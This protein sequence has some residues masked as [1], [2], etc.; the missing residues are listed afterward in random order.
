MRLGA[1]RLRTAVVVALAVAVVAAPGC[2][3]RRRKK[4]E[5]AIRDNV[6]APARY[7]QAWAELSDHNLRKAK[8][9]LEKIQFSAE[10]RT[11]LEPLVRLALADSVFYLGDDLS[12]IEAR[13]KYLDFVTLYGDHPKAPYAQFQAGMCSLQ[14]VR[15]PSR[16]QSQTLVAMDDLK[17]VIRRF[18]DSPFARAA[19][20]ARLRAEANVAEHEFL[21]ARFYLQR[22]K[23]RAA[24]DRFRDLLDKYPRY[25][26]KDKLYFHLAQAL[27]ASDNEAEGR[28]FLDRIV[29]DY[30]Q[31]EYA[32]RAKDL[33]GETPT[34][35]STTKETGA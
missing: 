15:A 6:A 19:E 12:L 24:T 32:G 7:E 25:R 8:L 17:E 31:G 16:D 23:Y 22:K 27:I 14:A 20:L 4:E 3:A 35:A 33:L 13:A 9:L 2:A 11:T 29:S 18:P 26:A 10:D 28:S 30:P 1:Q 34:T 21:V 5:A